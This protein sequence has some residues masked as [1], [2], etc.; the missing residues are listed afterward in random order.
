MEIQFDV[1]LYRLIIA[2]RKANTNLMA[3]K[4]NAQSISSLKG[5][6]IDKDQLKK[7]LE[8]IVSKDLF[9]ALTTFANFDILIGKESDQ[10]VKRQPDYRALDDDLAIAFYIASAEV[11]VME[12]LVQVLDTHGRQIAWAFVQTLEEKELTLFA[13]LYMPNSNVSWG[14]R[15]AKIKELSL[16]ELQ[17]TGLEAN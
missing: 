4:I 16:P 2:F 10:L 11:V 12:A 8:A 14:P 15:R 17:G 1:S 13:G 3:R 7:V 6:A 9:D 5:L